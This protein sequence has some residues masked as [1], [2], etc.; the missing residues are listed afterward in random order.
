MSL[1][2]PRLLAR[3]SALSS[4]PLFSSLS[5]SSASS[6]VASSSRR[7]ASSSEDQA[8]K[9]GRMG[10]GERWGDSP[11][12]ELIPKM[13]KPNVYSEIVPTHPISTDWKKI[14]QDIVDRFPKTI[15]G[16]THYRP[17]PEPKGT[18]THA[19]LAQPSTLVLGFKP[20]VVTGGWLCDGHGTRRCKGVLRAELTS[21][22][23]AAPLPA[24]SRLFVR[25]S[26]DRY[27]RC[28]PAGVWSWSGCQGQDWGC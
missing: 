21:V 19:Y 15:V 4:S 17:C 28:V 20:F 23:L 18:H 2:L 1:T 16:T 8:P 14:N 7:A 11:D 10:T 6:P 26:S 27:Y 24:C 25:F 12:Q 5:L 9:P 22:R 13:L 3:S